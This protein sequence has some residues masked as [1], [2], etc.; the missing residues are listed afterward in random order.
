MHLDLAQ[1]FL[2]AAIPPLAFVST[3]GAASFKPDMPTPLGKAVVRHVWLI[4]AWASLSTFLAYWASASGEDWLAVVAT[5]AAF[6]AYVALGTVV[7]F[8]RRAFALGK[9]KRR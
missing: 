7:V 8:S 2:F 9:Q 3:I 4:V 1:G 5:L 6:P